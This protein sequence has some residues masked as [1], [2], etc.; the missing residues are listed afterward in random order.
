MKAAAKILVRWHAQSQPCVPLPCHAYLLFHLSPGRIAPRLLRCGY[1][2]VTPKATVTIKYSGQIYRQQLSANCTPEIVRGCPGW[3]CGLRQGG[4]EGV[5][6]ML[7]ELALDH[8]TNSRAQASDLEI[9]QGWTRLAQ[10]Q[11]GC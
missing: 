5:S 6:T 8:M 4:Y 3:Q 10:H 7:P 2:T 9:K 1:E 11:S